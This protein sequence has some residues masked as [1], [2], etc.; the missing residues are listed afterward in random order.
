MK[1]RC[2]SLAVAAQAMFLFAFCAVPDMHAQSIGIGAGIA[3]SNDDIAQVT[4]DLAAQGWSGLS[5]NAGIGYY[6]ELR[7][8]TGGQLALIGSIG[9]T[10]FT[11]TRSQYLNGGNHTVEL[12]TAQTIIP[13]TLGADMRLSEGFLVPYITLEASYNQYYRMFRQAVDGDFLGTLEYESSGESRLGAVV[14]AGLS[15]D[16]KL[17]ELAVGGRLHLPNLI[18]ADEGEK[19]VYYMQLGATLFFG[20]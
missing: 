9:Y 5:E 13:V 20:M 3:V 18:N 17:A 15:M 14:G 2:I 12:M 19:E 8:R 11:E 4:T 1:N 16:L 6:A 10:H 7:G